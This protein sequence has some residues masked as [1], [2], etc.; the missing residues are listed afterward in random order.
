[1]E[2]NTGNF[3]WDGKNLQGKDCAEGVYFYVIHAKGK[4]DK[5]YEFKGHVTL[6]R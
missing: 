1:V 6:M 5:A 4:D 2:S 3:A